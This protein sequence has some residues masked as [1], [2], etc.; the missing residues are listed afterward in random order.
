MAVYQNLLF[1]S[2]GVIP[3]PQQAEQ[4]QNTASILIGLGGTGLRCL[5]AVKE[6]LLRRMMPDDPE[7]DRPEYAHIRFLGMDEEGAGDWDGLRESE[8]FPLE[9]LPVRPSDAPEFTW[10]TPEAGADSRQASRLRM[11]HRS[12]EFLAR[13]ER[14]I[15]TAKLQLVNPRVY[16]HIFAGLGAGVGSGCFLDVCYLSR[17]VAERFRD[18]SL[19]VELVG[20]F[21]LPDMDAQNGGVSAD[22]GAALRELDYCMNLPGNG[23]SFVQTYQGG[24][25]VAWNR[26]PVDLCHLLGTDVYGDPRPVIDTT[27]DYV[28]QLLADSGDE[29]ERPLLEALMEDSA[30]AAQRAEASRT[31][32][33]A[34]RYCSPGLS[35]IRLPVKELYT[36]LTA[37]FFQRISQI[38]TNTPTRKDVENLAVCSLAEEARSMEDV[39]ERLYG[40]ILGEARWEPYP[41]DRDIVWDVEEEGQESQETDDLTAHYQNQTEDLLRRCGQRAAALTE[42]DR[43]L[44]HRVRGALRS[45]VLDLERGPMFAWRMLNPSEPVHLLYLVDGLISENETRCR[46]EEARMVSREAETAKARSDFK[47]CKSRALFDTDAKRFEAYEA[48]TLR[49]HR[50]RLELAAY[51]SL[52]AVLRTFRER[53]REVSE[54]CY[55]KLG[56]VAANL[57]ETAAANQAALLEMPPESTSDTVPLLSIEE[58][59]ASVSAELN[60]SSLSNLTAAL[61]DAFLQNEDL[62]TGDREE[63]G[64]AVLVGRFVADLGFEDYASQTFT[65]FLQSRVREQ[66]RRMTDATLCRTVAEQWLLPL[67]ERVRPL[68]RLKPDFPRETLSYL[69]FPDAALRAAANRL[70]GWSPVESAVPDR[71]T[72]IRVEAGLPLWA[73]PLCAEDERVCG[74]RNEPGRFSYEGTPRDM[75]WPDWRRLPSVIP[76]SQMR[77]ADMDPLTARYTQDACALYEEARAHGAVDSAGYL[78]RPNSAALAQ[79]QAARKRCEALLSGERKS[80]MLV[81]FEAAADALSMLVPMERSALS[82]GQSGSHASAEDVL[83]V[84]KDRFV[85]SPAYHDR[86]RV[87]LAPLAEALSEQIADRFW[88]RMAELRS[89][90]DEAPPKRRRHRRSGR[91]KESAETLPEEIEEREESLSEDVPDDEAFN[92]E[93]DEEADDEDEGDDEYEEDDGDYEDDTGDEADHADTGR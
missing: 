47:G 39:Y 84:Q 21:F 36:C 27:A 41:K 31:H 59:Q 77:L 66:G 80:G 86:V 26:P 29:E 60:R 20:Y 6:R 89:A 9:R 14:E 88:E 55:E 15:D 61:M 4:A 8:C 34:V 72:A 56:Q 18:V 1:P 91:R 24:R 53:L 17:F 73:Y 62:W 33:A 32:G 16:L 64:V 40:E 48:S 68:F 22:G 69:A 70:E 43:S 49:L 42:G 11:M 30:A 38:S 76:Q 92:E 54:R 37:G 78:C 44:L 90:D 74:T 46:T 28:V 5:R 71:M 67:S 81:Q 65:E 45:V 82:L 10:L 83:R 63:E 35:S 79:L 19:S 51:Q 50:S 58:M 52:G 57:L 12:A 2:G 7:A 13:L 85:F 23:G 75:P 3:W 87:F 93:E 25:S